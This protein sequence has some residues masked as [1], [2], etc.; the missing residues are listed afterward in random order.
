MRGCLRGC[1]A[2]WFASAILTALFL[3]IPETSGAGTIGDN[4]IQKMLNAGPDELIPVLIR[5]AGAGLGSDL[6][7]ELATTY[8]RRADRHR[9]A[10]NRLQDEAQ[11]LQP[12]I[13][14]A[15]Q[16]SQ[17]KDRLA[18]VRSFWI[19]DAIAAQMTP[20]AI[21]EM[22]SH[23]D[24]GEVLYLP[25]IDFAKAAGP[26]TTLTAGTAAGSASPGIRAIRADSVWKLGYTGKGR[27]VASLDTGVDG[28]HIFLSDKWRGH[29]GYSVAE[30]WFN[31][32]S[33]DTVPRTIPGPFGGDTHGTETMGLMVAIQDQPVPGDANLDTVGVAFDAQWISAAVI[34]VQGANII[35]GMQWVADP[36]GDPNTE[37]DVPDVVNNSWGASNDWAGCSDIFWNAIDNVEAAGAAM[38]FVAGNEGNLGAESIRNPGNRNTSETN[39][40]SVGMIDVSNPSYPIHFLSSRGPSDC[41]HL[42]IKPE[43]V[44]PGVGIKST[45]PGDYMVQ[46]LLGTSF[47]APHVSGAIAL[48]REYNPNATVDEVKLA[49]LNS[50]LDLGTAGPDN[51]YGNGLIDVVEALKLMPPNSAPSLYV[52]HDYY[53]RPAPGTTTDMVIVLRSSGTAVNDVSVTVVSDDPRLSVTSAAAPFGDF[54][55]EGDTAGNFGTPFTLTVS[56]DALAGERLPMRFEISGSGGY[57]RTAHGALEVGPS[58]DEELFTHDAGNFIMTVSAFGTFG[59]E[60]GG[61]APRAGGQG[62]FYDGDPSQSLFEGAFLVGTDPDHVSDNARALFNFPDADFQTDPGGKLEVMEPGPEYAE[63]T[64]AAF[65]DANA[66][67]PLGLFI[68]QRTLVSDDPEDDDYLIAE[69]T[70]HNR[71]GALISGLRAGLFFDWDFPF[72]SG[73]FDDGGYDAAEGVGWMRN[74]YRNKFRGLAV[75]SSLGTTSY[76]YF[77]SN[78]TIY[79]GFTDA[80]KWAAMSGG[81]TQTTPPDYRDG[82]HLIA[83]GPYLL[84]ADGSVTVAFAIIGATSEAD[85]IA[86][87][88]HARA[89]YTPPA[90]LAIDILPGQCP[91]VITAMPLT[92]D[93]TPL[94]ASAAPPTRITVAIAGNLDFDVRSIDPLTIQLEGVTGTGHRYDDVMRPYVRETDDCACSRSG[95]DGFE[96]L[97]ID[98]DREELFAALGPILDGETRPLNLTAALLDRARLVGGDCAVLITGPRTNIPTPASADGITGLSGN[99]PNPF[100]A[101]TTISYSLAVEEHVQIRVYDLLGRKVAILRDEFQSAGSHT[102]LWYGIDDNN[103]P[104]ASGVYV[105]RLI[106]GSVSESRK[107]VLLK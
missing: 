96:D 1:R 57:A 92:P 80:E 29:N 90:P 9:E 11:R 100:N 13:L 10:V 33:H 54:P 104:V 6:K 4:L 83:T 77:V 2:G 91:N 72:L 40:F 50:A 88:Q 68:E 79:D 28:Q 74:H 84:P 35:E 85:L 78:P 14:A 38:I 98:F 42:S 107:M 19:D 94:S 34:D 46:G 5:P 70:I 58:Q 64:R 76:R 82:C 71:S 8:S 65:S 61:L 97:C 32:L 48:L 45:Y 7:R 37:L 17:Y 3:L 18:D 12:S 43:V 23:P 73:S 55:V 75:I 20:S 63:E 102:V 66:E 86:S 67:H 44:A 103:R 52:K 36:D 26:P 81:F 105:Y 53:T 27:L 106:A 47:A 21:A 62:Y 39:A 41:D 51:T 31:P 24:V 93:V 89:R 15:L 87:A 60:E 59:L 56:S 95:R 99:A 49:L 30:S 22:A 25:P 101:A 69:Y 16:S